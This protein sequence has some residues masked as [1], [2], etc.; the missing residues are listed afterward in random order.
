VY[1][2][3]GEADIRHVQALLGH[4]SLETTK[5]YLP[6]TPGHLRAEYDAAMPE[7]V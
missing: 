5:I 4:Q 7:L 1:L 3:R 6:M 2:L